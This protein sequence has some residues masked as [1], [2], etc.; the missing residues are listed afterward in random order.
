MHVH[1]ESLLWYVS[2]SEMQTEE[3]DFDSR[4]MQVIPYRSHGPVVVAV[5]IGRRALGGWT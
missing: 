4:L 5:F 3:N 2:L 1:S